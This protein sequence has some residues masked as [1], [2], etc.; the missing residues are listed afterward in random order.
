MHTK[1]GKDPHRDPREDET[2]ETDKD[3]VSDPALND[4]V[5]SDWVAEGGATEEGPATAHDG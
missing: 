5:G 3:I 4:Q 2:E 1:E